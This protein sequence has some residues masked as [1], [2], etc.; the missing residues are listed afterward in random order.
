MSGQERWVFERPDGTQLALPQHFRP[1]LT[2]PREVPMQP[3]RAFGWPDVFNGAPGDEYE[4]P[5]AAL[6]RLKGR[7]KAAS[8]S[9]LVSTLTDWRR[10]LAG[11]T[12]LK[13]ED[14]P[15]VA[16]RTW[17]VSGVRLTWAWP[18]GLGSEF[19]DVL[20]SG[21]RSEVDAYTDMRPVG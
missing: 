20:I 19:A 17:T 8:E 4:E 10:F 1:V 11:C 6:V 15:G 5:D 9:A 16:R 7:V 3:E 12:V 21:L 2:A 13:R 14:R 18:D